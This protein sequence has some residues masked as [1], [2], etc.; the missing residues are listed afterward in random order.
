MYLINLPHRHRESVIKHFQSNNSWRGNKSDCTCGTSLE[1][2]DFDSNHSE[3]WKKKGD[4]HLMGFTSEE[5][6]VSKYSNTSFLESIAEFYDIGKY[7]EHWVY[8]K[9]D[10]NPEFDKKDCDYFM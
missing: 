10:Y 9:R 3:R 2:V 4:N 1:I 6:D 7:I 8:N 5:D